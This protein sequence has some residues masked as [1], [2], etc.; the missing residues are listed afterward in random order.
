MDEKTEF[1]I[2]E[3]W[4]KNVDSWIRAIKDQE[5]ESRNLATNKSIVEVIIGL[6]PRKVLDVGCG[7]GWLV[8][9]LDSKG[10]DVFGVDAIPEFINAAISE[11]NGRYRTLTYKELS[12]SMLGEKF[13]VLVCNFS[14]FGK[15]SVLSLFQSAAQLLNNGGSLVVQTLHP[16]QVAG[17]EQT[18][19]GWREGSWAGFNA[20]FRD[21]APWYFRTT[22][23]WK[24]LFT[25]FGF[26]SLDIIEPVNPKTGLPA[27]I[28][29]AG[30]ISS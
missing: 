15:E 30:N 13:D 16:T 10:I 24:S 22:N 20:E 2:I 4:R 17:E 12:F 19:D 14:L 1:A 7:E 21:P 27:S 29:F 28:I 5:I 26:E 23:S 25:Q 8:R 9:E 18:H 11:G 3:S 6:A